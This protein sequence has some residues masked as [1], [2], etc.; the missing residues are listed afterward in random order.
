MIANRSDK[1]GIILAVK[2]TV[3]RPMWSRLREEDEGIFRFGK[4]ESIL[5]IILI[6]KYYFASSCEE[7]LKG[8]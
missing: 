3:C 1:L 7:S 8:Q 2:F 4:R 5:G 6:G